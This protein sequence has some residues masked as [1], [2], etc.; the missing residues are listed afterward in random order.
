MKKTD[1][2]KKLRFIATR[3]NKNGKLSEFKDNNGKVYNYEQ[4]LEI[5]EKGIVENAIPF[6]GRDGTR[7]IRGTKNGNDSTNLKKLKS[8]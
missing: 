2:K 1:S 5:V 3:R 8:F 4:A 7:H 6:T